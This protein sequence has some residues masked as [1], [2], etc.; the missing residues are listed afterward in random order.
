MG[1][2]EFHTGIAAI[3]AG[4]TCRDYRDYMPGV[5]GLHAGITGITGITA[6]GNQGNPG[7]SEDHPCRGGGLGGG[8]VHMCFFVPHDVY[9]C[10]RVKKKKL[11]RSYPLVIDGYAALHS[12]YD[13]HGQGKFR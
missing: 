1:L 7:N 6:V 12:W 9:M 2:P 10:P 11:G 13:G 4:I 3:T 5:P 8:Y